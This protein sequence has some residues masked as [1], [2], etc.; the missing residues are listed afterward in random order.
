MVIAVMALLPVV[1]VLSFLAGLLLFKRSLSWCRTCGS[2]LTCADC[3][4]VGRHPAH[5]SL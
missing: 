3:T 4:R 1:G 2:T 5:R